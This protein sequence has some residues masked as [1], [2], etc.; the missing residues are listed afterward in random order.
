MAA[1]SFHKF[2][3][4]PSEIQL[5]IWESSFRSPEAIPGGLHYIGLDHDGFQVPLDKTAKDEFRR[6][7]SGCELEQA[8]MKHQE[9]QDVEFSC[10]SFG[11]TTL[12]FTLDKREWYHGRGPVS[13]I[14]PI[15]QG[16]RNNVSKQQKIFI[17]PSR[18]IF[19]VALNRAGRA[20]RRG[21]CYPIRVFR[22]LAFEFEP[23]W[24]IKL[25][26]NDN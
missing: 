25:S 8:A 12:D 24:N 9:Q 22:G 10:S 14:P 23:S 7:R 21:N 1:S 20:V 4:L 13:I 6:P 3:E 11:L 15:D 2:P 17:C 16:Q 26:Q 18:D 19:C 5:Q